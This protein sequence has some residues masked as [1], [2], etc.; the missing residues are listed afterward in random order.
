MLVLL[1]LI[2]LYRPNVTQVDLGARSGCHSN[3]TE[4]KVVFF[5]SFFYFFT[6][7]LIFTCYFARFGCFACF[8][9]FAHFGGFV[10]AV[11]LSC[12]GFKYMPICAAC[13]SLFELR[14]MKLNLC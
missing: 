9:R 8:G 13:Y 7:L 12:F 4:I 10:S 2:H 3:V 5:I 6:Y 14:H 11:L 1:V